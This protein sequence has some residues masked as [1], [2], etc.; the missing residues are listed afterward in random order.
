MNFTAPI[1]AQ[2]MTARNLFVRNS[3]TEFYE[4]QTSGLLADN[5]PRADGRTDGRKDVIST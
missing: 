3:C 1:F 5:R 2:L 4:T